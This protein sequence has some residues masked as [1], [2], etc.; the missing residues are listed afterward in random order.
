[1]TELSATIRLRPTR[2]GFLVKPTDFSSVRKIMRC[3]SCVWGGVYNPI[4]PVFRTPPAEWRPEPFERI[5][6]PAVALGHVRFFEPD[7]YVEAET[8]LLEQAGLGSLREKYNLHPQ[9]LTLKEFLTPRDHRDWAEPAFGLNICDVLGHI[10][11]TEEQFQARDKRENLLVKVDRSNALAEAIFGVYPPQ[12]DATYFARTYKDA[13]KPAEVSATP[14]AWLK[15]F[16]EGAETPLHVTRYDL[17]TQRFW[18]H[19][20]VVFVFDPA[21]STDLI[22]LWNLRL[23]PK[24]ILPVPIDWFEPLGDFIFDAL[25]AEHRPI[26]GNP[27][28]LMHH[29]TVEFARSISK[30]RAEQLLKTIKPGLPTGAFHVKLFRTHIWDD[31]RDDMVHRD[32]RMRITANERGVNLTVK[33][34]KSLTTTFETLAPDFASRY[35]GHDYRWIN[36]AKVG[37]YSYGPKHVATVLPFNLTDRDWPRLGLGGER[38][39]I[40]GEGWIYPQQYKNANQYVTLLKPEE[41]IIEWLEKKKIKAKLS[42]PGHIAKQMLE[43]LGGLWGAYLLADLETLQLLNKMAGGVRKKANDWDTVEESFELR[44]A[45]LKDWGDLLARRKQRHQLPE[46]SIEDF[47]KRNVIRLGLETEC[48][49]CQATNWS[50]LTTVDYNLTCSRCLKTYPFPE[51]NI[52]DHNR[53]W[54]YRVVGPF[55][56]PDF[57]R[58]S[59][60]ALLALRVLDRFNAS[61]DEMTFATAMKLDGEGLDAEV[62]FIAWHR[63]EK[64]DNNLPP[65]TIIGE[66][67]SGGKGQL[68]KA[69]DIA[70]LKAVAAKLPG[71]I[72]VIAV[73]RNHFLPAEKK[74]LEKFVTWARRLDQHGEPTN[75]VLLLTANELLMDHYISDTWKKLGEPHAKYTDFHSIR[76]LRAFANATQNIYLSLPSFHQWRDEQWRKRAARRAGSPKA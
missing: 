15:M 40:G 38:I 67:K 11:K 41:A 62:D 64:L 45:P 8:G 5:T 4:I 48:P 28:K 49:H 46:I 76:S 69:R 65:D 13:L 14:E 71:A 58:G 54:F 10:Y 24:P 30:E 72:I 7:V 21:R 16:K 19:E 22:D 29:S 9:V 2:I 39:V 74:L 25:K 57:A 61:H 43:Q 60:S 20:L 33:E 63:E 36:A 17:D 32:D 23:E 73:L 59:Y 6:G 47:T 31:Y 34:D 70:Q 27:Q 66:A 26:R 18:H 68:L 53:N 1:M 44:A 52:R 50:S 75:P 55:S 3:C 37:G 42:E 56:V 51:A 12:K 35:G